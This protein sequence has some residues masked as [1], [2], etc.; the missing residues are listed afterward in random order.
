MSVSADTN[1][2]TPPSQPEPETAPSQPQP[3][4]RASAKVDLVFDT[5][6]GG[7]I[8]G[9]VIALFFLV[10]DAVAG[11]ALFTP[12][13]MGT[14]LFTGEAVSAATPVSRDLVVLYSIVHFLVFGGVAMTMS[15][16]TRSVPV[17][18]ERPLVVAGVVFAVL[19]AALLAAD[20]L[21][22]NGAIAAIGIAPVLAANAVTGL[23]MAVF[24]RWSQSQVS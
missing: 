2:E 22:L 7:G 3:E 17:L 20:L 24:F 18:R 12:S 9:S 15:W 5:F 14:A 6:F 10:V 23:A 4:P 11:R 16:L 1:Q 21:V 13:V 8:G 19:T